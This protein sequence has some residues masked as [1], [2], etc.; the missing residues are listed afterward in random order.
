MIFPDL[1]RLKGPVFDLFPPLFSS[2]KRKFITK[3]LERSQVLW[4]RGGEKGMKIKQKLKILIF[5]E[6]MACMKNSNC[7]NN[8]LS[9]LFSC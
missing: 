5:F 8:L 3:Q 4:I 2:M 6:I 1:Y 7:N 9:L